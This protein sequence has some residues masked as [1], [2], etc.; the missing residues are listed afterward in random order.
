M[1]SKQEM[2]WKI[3]LYFDQ[4]EIGNAMEKMNSCFD[5]LSQQRETLHLSLSTSYAGD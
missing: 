1:A 2:L 3:K 4:E 5:F